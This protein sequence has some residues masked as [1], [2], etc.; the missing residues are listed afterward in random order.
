[1][2]ERRERISTQLR[3]LHKGRDTPPKG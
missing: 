1:V 2:R 3:D